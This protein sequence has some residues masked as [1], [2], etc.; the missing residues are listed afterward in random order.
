MFTQWQNCVE[1]GYKRASYTRMVLRR[2]MDFQYL[3]E[4]CSLTKAE[5]KKYKK[6]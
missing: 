2:V 1:Q 6:I 3:D 5:I 4:I